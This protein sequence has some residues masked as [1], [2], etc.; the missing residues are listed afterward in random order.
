M[1][2]RARERRD[3]RVEGHLSEAD[4]Q[5]RSE[6]QRDLRHARQRQRMPLGQMVEVERLEDDDA[7][8]SVGRMWAR[9]WS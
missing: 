5:H 7:I 8:S 2:R 1:L 9:A 3:D 4:D 6:Q